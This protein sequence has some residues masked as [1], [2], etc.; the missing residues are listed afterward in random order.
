MA[1]LA[2]N[3]LVTKPVAFFKGELVRVV[4]LDFTDVQG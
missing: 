4:V 1:L 3:K 2:N